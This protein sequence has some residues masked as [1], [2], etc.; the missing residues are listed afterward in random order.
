M[1]AWVIWSSGLA[2]IA[3]I[4]GWIV[5]AAQQPAS[6]DSVRDTISALAAR[7]AHDRWI[8]TAGLALLGTCH[9]ATAAGLTQ[10]G[11]VARA[12][13]ALGGAASLAVAALAQPNP[14]HVPTATVAFVALAVWPIWSRLPNR[15][16][17]RAAAAGLVVLLVGLLIELAGSGRLLGLSE[18]GVAG[19]EAL[20]PLVVTLTVAGRLRRA[21]R[22]S[23]AT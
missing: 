16:L 21:R 7:G 22:R 23:A 11:A 15:R 14:A 1:R 13:L 19:A 10:A 17:A 12:L 20:W 2:P 6:Y 4:G 5:A 18:R 3:L 8:M 9:L